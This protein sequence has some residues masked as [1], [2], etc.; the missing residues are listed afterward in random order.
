MVHCK[1]FDT[2][3][4]KLSPTQGAF[5]F[6]HEEHRANLLFRKAILA[7]ELIRTVAR[8]V[9]VILIASDTLCLIAH[10]ARIF[11]VALPQ[12]RARFLDIPITPRPHLSSHT[13]FAM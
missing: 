4:A 10:T 6:L 2:A 8:R 1:R 11:S 3:Y 9:R 5:A 7:F 12:I 13:H